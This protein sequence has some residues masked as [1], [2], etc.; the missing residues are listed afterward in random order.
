[1]IY[2]YKKKMLNIFSQRINF[3]IYCGLFVLILVVFFMLS[4][5]NKKNNSQ[6]KKY[7]LK[8]IPIKDNYI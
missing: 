4:P 5:N 8:M 7:H 6:I 1:M 3:F 2:L